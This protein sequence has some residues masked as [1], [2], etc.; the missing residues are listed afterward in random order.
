MDLNK[1]NMLKIMELILYV[2]L[3]VAAVFNLD[4][5]WRTL[6]SIGSIL[7]PFILGGI[8][9]FILNVPMKFFE[10]HLFTNGKIKDTKFVKK[11]A[12]P[13]SLIIT[14]LVVIGVIMVGVLV[15]IPKLGET[16]IG[17]GGTIQ[18]FAGEVQMWA[19]KTFRDNPDIIKE[20]NSL[21]FNWDQIVNS[22]INFLKN[23]AGNVLSS[24]MNVAK[25][26]VDA[27]TTFGIA[28]VFS[29]YILLQKEVLLVQVKKVLAALFPIPW[30]EKFL[31]VCDLTSKTFSSFLT[32]Q[33]VEAVILG[34]MFFVVMSIIRLPYALLIGVLIAFTALIP[35]FGA[36]IGCVLGAFF[37]LMV[38]P[39]KALIFLIVF[40]V[41]QQVEGNLIY[42]HVVG[43]SV[44]LPSIWVLVAVSLGASLMGVVGM[45]VFIPLTS[46]FYTLFRKF[47]Y[48]QLE[49]KIK[50]KE[51]QEKAE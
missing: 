46:V 50:I 39:V 18:Q 14:L 38:S 25:S 44:G 22:V 31:D 12:R 21:E 8:F 45:L 32:G 19:E 20:I 9:A 3:L 16:V 2:V 41:L 4:V 17:M 23:G 27:V 15:I 49:K 13:F 36:F 1:K 28:F 29:C 11:C 6:G 40:L 34:T 43:G 30:V 33:C 10:R 7:F 26:I 42:P 47:V 24:T 5:I 35:V 37:I 51:K 48:R